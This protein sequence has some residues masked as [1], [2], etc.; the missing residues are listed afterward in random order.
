[1][2]NDYSS[3]FNSHLN[4]KK[5]NV[6]NDNTK[7]GASINTD[8]VAPWRRVGNPSIGRGFLLEIPQRQSLERDL[9]IP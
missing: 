8:G 6:S 4:D 3:P 2:K 5:D 9:L 7:G 1:M